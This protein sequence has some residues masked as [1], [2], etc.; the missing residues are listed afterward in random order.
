MTA[1]FG[2]KLL[3]AFQA[4]VTYYESVFLNLQRC[5]KRIPSSFN[6]CQCLILPTLVLK[7]DSNQILNN[8]DLLSFVLSRVYK[9]CSRETVEVCKNVKTGFHLFVVDKEGISHR[10]FSHSTFANKE[11]EW[12]L[13]LLGCICV[14]SINTSKQ[15]GNSKLSNFLLIWCDAG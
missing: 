10:Q 15:Q 11:L 13:N 9:T 4:R 14:C 12:Y 8:V 3:C 5:K 2:S 1:Q 7:K 6:T